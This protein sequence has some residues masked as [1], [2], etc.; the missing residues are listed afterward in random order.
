MR[1]VSTTTG[2][3]VVAVLG[4]LLVVGVTSTVAWVAISRAGEEVLDAPAAPL[5]TPPATSSPSPSSPSPSS[6]SPTA[7]TATGSPTASTSPVTPTGSPS[8]AGYVDRT[9]TVTGGQVTVRCLGAAISLRAATPV[10]G[11]S[12]SAEQR[13]SVEVRVEFRS[14]E[15]ESK[16]RAV[17][18]AGVPQIS[19][20]GDGT[21]GGDDDGG[22][23]GSGGDGED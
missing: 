4:W 6:A 12:V 21:G 11:W 2:R 8:T 1:G 7:P 23:G 9:V 18:G 5:P 22:G 20:E 3:W 14:G 16:V 19:V 15:G 13:G 10:S 17:C